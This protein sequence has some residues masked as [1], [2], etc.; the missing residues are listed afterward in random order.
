MRIG[1]LTHHWVYNFGANLQALAINRLLRMLGHDAWIINYRPI[2]KE[3]R[4]REQVPSCQVELHEEVCRKFMQQT[5]LCTTEA[6]II[7]VSG[8]FGFDAIWVGSDAVFRLDLRS[9]Q[10]DK[11]FP[12]PFWLQWT[13]SGG[14]KIPRKEALAV[15]AMGTNFLTLPR[16]IRKGI[17]DA[18]RA[19]HGISVRDRWTWLMLSLISGGRPSIIFCPDPVFVLNDIC[20]IPDEYQVELPFVRDKYILLSVERNQ[21][22]DK[23]I[24]DFVRLSHLHGFLVVSLPFPENQVDLPVDYVIPLP[25]SPLSWYSLIKN[26]SGFVGYRMHPIVC[27]MVNA[28]PFV[29]IDTYGWLRLFG[30]TIR[31]RY[32]SKTYDLCSLAGLARFCLSPKQAR[33]CRP[34]DILNLLLSRDQENARRFSQKAKQDFT[35]VV[36]RFLEY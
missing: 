10:P 36:N 13:N 34:E 23:W 17:K 35:R 28:V 22:T 26:S 6:D 1:I 33:L 24:N 2:E 7:R 4:Y 8:D 18:I 15:S 27:S 30:R 11:T 31:I 25:L 19:M 3:A 5:P 16:K 12:N 14:L 29:S 20:R 21:F 32:S 9:N